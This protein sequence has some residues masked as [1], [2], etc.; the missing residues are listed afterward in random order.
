MTQPLE[1]PELRLLLDNQVAGRSVQA[2]IRLGYGPPSAPAPRRPIADVL[3]AA[4]GR[5]PVRA[6]GG[7]PR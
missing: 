2:I 3:V 7:Y 5:S 4:P 6:K 1:T